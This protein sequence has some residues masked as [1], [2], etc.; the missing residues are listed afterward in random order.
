MLRW[1]VRTS[2]RSSQPLSSLRAERR[3][4]NGDQCDVIPNPSAAASQDIAPYRGFGGMW[5]VEGFEHSKHCYAANL[6]IACSTNRKNR[7][8]RVR[9]LSLSL[10]RFPRSEA[11]DRRKYRR[12]G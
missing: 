5:D 8:L 12:V 10:G 6:G 9:D 4:S 1:R 7:V 3:R 11:G 2:G